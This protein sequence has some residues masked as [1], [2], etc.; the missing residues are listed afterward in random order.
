MP[1]GSPP[2]ILVKAQEI[3]NNENY[4]N[5][6]VP[7]P[8]YV[9]CHTKLYWIDNQLMNGLNKWG[10]IHL[11]D[12]GSQL[13]YYGEFELFW[14]SKIHIMIWV[15]PLPKATH[16][17]AKGKIQSNCKLRTRSY[18]LM[19]NGSGFPHWRANNE[20]HS[21]VPSFLRFTQSS[22]AKKNR[23]SRNNSR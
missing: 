22:S 16:K 5:E 23:T 18:H 1:T 15:L 2:Y 13:M 12:N 21:L 4:A 14:S 6:Y 19:L 7:P 9:D 20:F 3:C 17:D 10:S 11:N 8:R